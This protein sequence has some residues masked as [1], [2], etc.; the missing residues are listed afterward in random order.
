MKKLIFSLAVFSLCI[1]FEEAYAYS[2]Q[3]PSLVNPFLNKV[4]C[5][6]TQYE[7]SPE[8]FAK[9][10]ID[11]PNAKNGLTLISKVFDNGNAIR[12]RQEFDLDNGT[13]N[14]RNLY[15]QNNTVVCIDSISP[16]LLIISNISEEDTLGV[17]EIRKVLFD[18]YEKIKNIESTKDAQITGSGDILTIS[19]QDQYAHNATINLKTKTVEEYVVRKLNG[20]LYKK[21][22]FDKVDL[23]SWRVLL[24]L[25]NP[26]NVL[27]ATHTLQVS[28]IEDNAFANDL[29]PK[30]FGF[31]EVI[32][33]RN[34]QERKYI[35]VD[36][37][38]SD[39]FIDE[40]FKN[41]DDVKQYNVEMSR[42]APMEYK[43]RIKKK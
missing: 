1:C 31:R 28:V 30:E 33:T 42:F 3:L 22:E 19:W 37:L 36:K 18:V 23:D 16:Y 9:I 7:I 6:K 26:N 8:I 32:D 12:V 25:Y 2:G 34:N 40:L 43:S 21:L 14:I 29:E 24:K 35:A 38:P 11:M 4:L 13:K 39:K 17:L 41:P 20:D 27:F 5:I 10:K 15:A